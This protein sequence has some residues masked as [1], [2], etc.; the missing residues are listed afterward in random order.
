MAFITGRES[1]RD[2]RRRFIAVQLDDGQR[3]QAGHAVDVVLRLIHEHTHRRHK[4]WQRLRDLP[5]AVRI[6]ETGTVG[7]ED[8][9]NR[10]RAVRHG[11]LGI[12]LRE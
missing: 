5:G 10:R 4:W 2:E 12:L 11:S 8:E 7:P 6:D 3:H 1:V 9:P